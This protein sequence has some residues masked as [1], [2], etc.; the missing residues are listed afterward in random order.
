MSA[1]AFGAF[2][3]VELSNRR[4]LSEVGRRFRDTVLASGGA[5]HPHDV[6]QD[7]RGRPP[8]SHALLKS[9]GFAWHKT[10]RTRHGDLEEKRALWFETSIAE[11][12][13]E[14]L[15]SYQLYSFQLNE[16]E[17]HQRLAPS[18]VSARS[19]MLFY[20]ENSRDHN[21]RNSMHYFLLLVCGCF[22]V[23]QFLW[24]SKSCETGPTVSSPYS[25]RLENLTIC[26]LISKAEL[27]PQLF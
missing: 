5:R 23:P 7:F 20:R 12:Q 14:G 16:R 19:Q 21:I 18:W 4:A 8:S 13:G 27:P 9:Y 25:R 17:E 3:E 15:I 2:E 24:T 11:N 10:S 6:F 1:D 26:R 22:N